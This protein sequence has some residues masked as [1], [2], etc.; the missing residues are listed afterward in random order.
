MNAERFRCI[1]SGLSQYELTALEQRFVQSAEQSF[2]RKRK[3]AEE[4]ESILEGSYTEKTRFVYDAMV[5]MR[6]AH[7]IR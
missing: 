2:K 4:Q 7:R 5:L 3:L 1:V 6:A